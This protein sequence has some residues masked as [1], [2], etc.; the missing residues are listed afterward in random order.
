MG[1]DST[2][3]RHADDRS[4]Y[5]VPS[6]RLAATFW[7]TNSRLRVQRAESE[8]F[9]LSTHVLALWKCQRHTHGDTG[10]PAW[11]RRGWLRQP[12]E[13]LALQRRP[14]A[15][16]DGPRRLQ[17]QRERY[18][19]VSFSGGH[20]AA[21]RVDGPHQPAVQCDF[22]AAPLLVCGRTHARL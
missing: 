17:H 3:H 19:L 4:Q 10:L 14:R 5:G 20:W 13:H 11:R 12:A 7:G 15:G 21:S 2:A 6:I 22:A 18:D 8:L 16:T 9:V 1:K